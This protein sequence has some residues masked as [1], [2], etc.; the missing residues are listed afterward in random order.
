M[1]NSFFEFNIPNNQDSMTPGLSNALFWN[2]LQVHHLDVN[3]FSRMRSFQL[4]GNYKQNE[5]FSRKV[6]I[7]G[8]PPDI[9]E[10]KS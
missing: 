2:D 3:T 9:G 5:I 10:G 7:G 8:L 6:F 4:P 1:D